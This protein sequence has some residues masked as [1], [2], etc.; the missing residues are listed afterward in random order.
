MTGGVTPGRFSTL[1]SHRRDPP[2]SD[3]WVVKQVYIRWWVLG[4]SV[5]AHS[6][7]QAMCIPL[8]LLHWCIH[9]GSQGKGSSVLGHVPIEIQPTTAQEEYLI[10]MVMDHPQG[11]SE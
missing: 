11:G 7:I 1:D 10:Q 3:P 4:G 8:A 9:G 5:Y 2:G 6:S